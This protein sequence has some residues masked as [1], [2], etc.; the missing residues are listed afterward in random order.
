MRH[1]HIDGFLVSHG[2]STVPEYIVSELNALGGKITNAYGIDVSQLVEVAHCGI[3][4]INV[5]TDLR[6][7]VTR[8]LRELFAFDPSLQSSASIGGV[9]ELLMKYPEKFDP[10]VFFV[11]LMDMVM[12][13]N[14]KDTDVQRLSRAVEDG[15]KEALAPL[16]VKFGSYGKAPQVE[17]VSLEEM[18]QRYKNAGI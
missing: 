6:L 13:G 4:K 5:D 12:Y 17:A 11:P 10:R 15:V 7:A 8:N 18:A 16:I 3:N 2:S 9:Y 1:E 14:E